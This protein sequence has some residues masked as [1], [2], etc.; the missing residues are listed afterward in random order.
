LPIPDGIDEH[1]TEGVTDN[2]EDVTGD[3]WDDGE[4]DTWGE[5]EEEKVVV[6]ARKS[7]Q[8]EVTSK[9]VTTSSLSS[10]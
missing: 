7:T 4:T 5:E 8:T 3:V 2:A 1:A 6:V 10:S 9:K